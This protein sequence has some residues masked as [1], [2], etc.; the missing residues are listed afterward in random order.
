MRPATL[1][2]VTLDITISESLNSLTLTNTS[3][4]PQP[5]RYAA[6]ANFD[7]S[8]SASTTDS[9]VLDASLANSLLFGDPP[10]I[11]YAP[12]ILII[13]ANGTLS[14]LGLPSTLTVS[15]GV[16]NLP[17][18]DYYGTGTYTL[19][20]STLTTITLLDNGCGCITD[21]TTVDGGLIPDTTV[22]PNLTTTATATVVYT[23]P[24]P[25]PASALLFTG[26]LL[27]VPFFRRKKSARACSGK[28]ERH[29][30]AITSRPPA[31]D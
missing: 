3:A 7:V 19:N 12:G 23:T 28:N 15:T 6:A 1:T 17:P 5:V 4:V 24:T 9:A 8:V 29:P 27:A 31:V 13:P 18:A 26:G 30:R 10:A 20:Y 2:S 11:F 14:P 22:Y 25:E 21:H 16:I